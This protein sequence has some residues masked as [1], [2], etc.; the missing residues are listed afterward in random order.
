VELFTLHDSLLAILAV[1]DKQW[2]FRRGSSSADFGPH[3]TLEGSTAC[4]P[5]LMAFQYTRVSS[6]M[7]CNSLGY[8]GGHI[9][10]EAD[11]EHRHFMMARSLIALV[12]F[13]ARPLPPS[14]DV[15]G[16]VLPLP[17]CAF[18]HFAGVPHLPPV[19]KELSCS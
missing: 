13:L 12:W 7:N 5:G 9:P 15:F 18:T 1:M 16:P 10:E 6:E 2:H 14:I 3:P 17:C 4:Y 19:P 11:Q 8:G